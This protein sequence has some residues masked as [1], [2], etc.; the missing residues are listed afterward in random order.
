[1]RSMTLCPY[2]FHRV[3]RTRPHRVYMRWWWL[4]TG[5]DLKLLIL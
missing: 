4:D 1:M 2:H 5:L 3:G